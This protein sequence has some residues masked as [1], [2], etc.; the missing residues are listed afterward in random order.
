M[1]AEA[2]WTPLEGPLLVVSPHFDDAALSCAALVER[3]EPADVLTVF[4]GRPD[5]PVRADWDVRCGFLDS[6][7]A[8]A[9][10]TAEDRAAFA[11]TSHRVGTLPLLQSIYLSAERPPADAAALAEAVR[12]WAAATPHGTVALPAGAGAPWGRRAVYGR[13][14]RRLSRDSTGLPPHPEHLLVRDVA[15]RALA[16]HPRVTPVLYEEMPYSFGGRADDSVA[17]V[18]RAADRSAALL[19]LRVDREAK[20]ERIRAYRSQLW[21]LQPPLHVPDVVPATE[22]YWRLERR[23]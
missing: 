8:I 5:P 23:G 11:S 10:R 22:R 17:A 1:S 13:L 15:V 2:V 7:E 18:A 3:R 20:A 14:R 9:A 6:D 21:S 16:E 19:T 4:G 12:S